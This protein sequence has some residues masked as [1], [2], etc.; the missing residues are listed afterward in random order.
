[1]NESTH[2]EDSPSYSCC[3]HVID[4]DVG[5]VTSGNRQRFV[6]TCPGMAIFGSS[7]AGWALLGLLVVLLGDAAMHV[8]REGVA[9]GSTFSFWRIDEPS[10]PSESVLL[11][12]LL[13]GL[14]IDSL[15][16]SGNPRPFIIEEFDEYDDDAQFAAPQE[17]VTTK[18]APV[19]IA[20]S[21]DS[22]HTESAPAAL[23]EEIW[24]REDRSNS[25]VVME[26]GAGIHLN[27]EERKH[28]FDSL[29]CW[30]GLPSDTG[31]W[32]R[33]NTPAR[34]QQKDTLIFKD[35][36]GRTTTVNLTN[37]SQVASL[38][39]PPYAWQPR[40]GCPL[41]LH[42]FSRDKLCGLM[43]WRRILFV[44]DAIQG[45]FFDSFADL[46]G[47]QPVRHGFSRDPACS[48]RLRPDGSCLRKEYRVCE[49]SVLATFVRN[50]LLDFTSPYVG[51]ARS[52]EAPS[53]ADLR[54]DPSMRGISED[55][56][57]V[58]LPVTDILYRSISSRQH[59]VMVVTRGWS[60]RSV[61]NYQVLAALNLSLSV[62]RSHPAHLVSHYGLA[63]LE[64]YDNPYV[65]P[66]DGEEVSEAGA[67]SPDATSRGRRRRRRDAKRGRRRRGRGAARRLRVKLAKKQFRPPLIV[68]REGV[69]PGLH[70]GCSSDAQP[71]SSP[72]AAMS[73]DTTGCGA[74][75]DAKEQSAR[76]ARFLS[77]HYP[78]IV[79]L[80]VA[81]STSMRPD[82]H[83]D[84]EAGECEAY[85]GLGPYDHWS[86]LLFNAI[87]HAF[88]H[89]ELWDE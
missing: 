33:D 36:K 30:D 15:D 65:E 22:L 77:A 63:P 79:Q 28:L 51:T 5:E 70:T 29:S 12:G 37:A 67:P 14:D 62:L 87:T 82:A 21:S 16:D 88:H 45:G 18:I 17:S 53:E 32:A 2:T 10:I 11:S 39:A 54:L 64:G 13:T 55:G 27:Q 80:P 49:G 75:C 56:A 52:M 44:G 57:H 47:K 61:P 25:H 31:R 72:P 73:A 38:Q 86:R 41:Q 74:T 68:Y 40:P 46:L 83:Y 9:L 58:L 35:A 19:V 69:P 1:M 89:N 20:G 81:I 26:M 4:C 71:L 48:W 50:D 85:Q 76:I 23:E 7:R 78:G 42:Q 43:A 66:E 6:V 59:D 60:S 3:Q 34:W 8:A 84:P 24:H